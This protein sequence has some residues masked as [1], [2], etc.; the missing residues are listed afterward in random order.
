M[1]VGDLVREN[2]DNVCGGVGDTLGIVLDVDNDGIAVVSWFWHGKFG[3][4]E[5]Y[6]TRAELIFFN[7]SA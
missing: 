7:K 3:P 5:S 4:H 2:P 6:N 1:K